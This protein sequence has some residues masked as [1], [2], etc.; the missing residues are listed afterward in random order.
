[1]QAHVIGEELRRRKCDLEKE[2]IIK[3]LVNLALFQI[4]QR[5]QK[6]AQASEVKAI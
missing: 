2:K 4:Q 5:N 6:T 3:K 1:M